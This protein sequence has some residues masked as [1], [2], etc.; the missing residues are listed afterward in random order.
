MI[1]P[2]T[3]LRMKT[4]RF[5]LFAAL[6]AFSGILNGQDIFLTFS[7][8]RAS[9]TVD[10]VKVENIS[11]G[12]K[13]VIAGNQV[14]HLE[15]I[16]TGIHNSV[17]EVKRGVTF[18]PNPMNEF[19]IMEFSI[20]DD[21]KST[22]SI[23]DVGGKEILSIQ[24]YLS[25]GNHSYRITGMKPGIY[26]AS[27][28]SGQYSATGSFIS[29]SGEGSSKAEYISKISGKDMDKEDKPI[30]PLRKIDLADITMHFRQGDSLRF[31]AKSG[32]FTT[33]LIDVPDTSK[34]MTFDFYECIDGDKNSYPVVKTGNNIWMAENLKTTSFNDG[35][36]IRYE[37][38][39]NTWAT[40]DDKGIPAFSWYNNKEEYKNIYG[41]LY[42]YAAVGTTG[43]NVCPVGWHIATNEWNELFSFLDKHS[44]N[45]ELV[46]AT[47]GNLLKESGTIHWSCPGNRATNGSGFA[48]LP[49]GLRKNGFSQMGQRAYFWDGAEKYFILYCINGHADHISEKNDY[50]LSVRCVKD[51]SIQISFSGNGAS[52][53][54]SSVRVENLNTGASKTVKGDQTLFLG[55]EKGPEGSVSME[56]ATGQKLKYTGF[57]DKYS[58][59]IVDK[60][61]QDTIITFN[62]MECT[63]ADNNN[64]PV[65]RIGSDI[66]MAEN[67]KTT[68]FNDGTPIRNLIGNEEWVSLSSKIP[69]YCWYNNDKGNK[70]IY[71]GLYNFYVYWNNDKNVCP[72]GWHVSGAGHIAYSWIHEWWNLIKY[73]DPEMKIDDSH[74]VSETA[75]IK[76]KE[77]G[78]E[79]WNCENNKATN[80]TGF[81]A[82]PGGIRNSD[83]SFYN[84]SASF[85]ESNGRIS[86]LCDGSVWDYEGYDDVGYS[87]RCVKDTSIIRDVEG[88]IYEIVEIGSQV[89][90]K[91]SLRTTRLNDG[92]QIE[93]ISDNDSAWW[94]SVTPAYCF[95]PESYHRWGAIY[96]W[97][98]VNT[99]RL[100]PTG[101]HVPS[102]ADWT[103]LTKY[104]ITNGYNFDGSHQGNKIGKSMALPAGSWKSSNTPGAI[105]NNDYPAKMNASSYSAPP[106]GTRGLTFSKSPNETAVFWSST[107]SHATGDYFILHFNSVNGFLT[108]PDVGDKQNG[109]AVRC[110]KDK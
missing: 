106:G 52:D 69:A 73:L 20:P 103:E 4:N 11:F 29:I 78:T 21:G 36:P 46:S 110:L 13:L 26:F 37:K 91:E 89:W 88:N 22:I 86:L 54:V 70:D 2:L 57:S 47:A 100:C 101:W 38:D 61:Y 30:R 58:T 77:T 81:S 72:V 23:I 59:V 90:M 18:S 6:F 5:F 55:Q 60:P 34:T 1:L 17:R 12:E 85:W 40:L 87:I 42:N 51:K 41:G 49:G 14:L 56:Y 107:P 50:G 10:S 39:D 48:A 99:G 67:L 7:G 9:N 92:T 74:L 108:S 25:A 31:T 76:L 24:D 71:G 83:G 79:H 95:Y 45:R 64:Y 35:I 98:S 43:K 93:L 84:M 80:E 97:Q 66:W 94:N 104:L 28:I 65:V 109:W 75:G 44:A 8:V 63:D 68:K 15:Q 105:G 16:V 19:S 33:I 96:N 102:D 62:F 3:P 27:I 53:L 32:S 82:K